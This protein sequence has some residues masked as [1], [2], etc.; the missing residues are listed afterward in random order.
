ML[1]SGQC[2][3]GHQLV[4]IVGVGRIGSAI[5]HQSRPQWRRVVSPWLRLQVCISKLDIPAPGR[6]IHK[7]KTGLLFHVLV[8]S[9]R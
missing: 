6:E 4:V 2:S 8:S 1:T 9:D 7:L 3:P 5:R